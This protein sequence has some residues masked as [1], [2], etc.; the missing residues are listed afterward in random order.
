MLPGMFGSLSDI[1]A[2]LPL[3]EFIQAFR[4]KRRLHIKA[5]ATSGAASLLPWQDLEA[6]ISMRAFDDL[7]LMKNG[8]VI[9]PQLY[10]GEGDLAA[11][12]DIVAQGASLIIKQVHLSVPRIQWLATSIERQLGC[13]VG[14]NAYCSFSSG[15]AF[16]PHWDRHDVLVVQLHGT[17]AWRLWESAFKNPVERSRDAKHDIT[18]TPSDEF[19]V[20]PGD[21]LFIPRGEPHAASVSGGA[22]V[23]LTF[24]IDSLNGVDVVQRLQGAA[25]QDDFLRADLP[26]STAHAE[27]RE[28][29]NELKAR[30]HRLVDALDLSEFLQ[31]DHARRLPVRQAS[32]PS[33]DDPGEILRLTLRRQVPLPEAGDAEPAPVIIGGTSHR[34]SRAAVEILRRLFVRDCQSRGALIEALSASHDVAAVL[35]G[36]RELVRLGFLMTERLV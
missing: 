17:K 33:S 24:G 10:R 9:P 25:G 16:K 23:H 35:A 8:M 18:G 28:H 27:L 5:V 1:L 21:V 2:P 12:H 6:L 14:A 32:L 31:D 7:E 34:L 15:G 3:P 13:A 19:V 11:F 4:D 36:L 22:S 26:P 30:L 20:S 29:E